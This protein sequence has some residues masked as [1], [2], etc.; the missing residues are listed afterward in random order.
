[1][2]FLPDNLSHPHSHFK[3]NTHIQSLRPY[4]KNP[5]NNPEFFLDLFL[6]SFLGF[7]LDVFC[8]FLLLTQKTQDLTSK[9]IKILVLDFFVQKEIKKKNQGC[10]WKNIPPKNFV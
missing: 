7:S 3:I 1:M 4:E 8:P 5:K 9:K 2:C 10:L 6:D